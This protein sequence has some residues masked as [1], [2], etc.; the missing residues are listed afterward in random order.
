MSCDR[1]SLNG[2]SLGCV[3]ARGVLRHCMIA[4]FKIDFRD[5]FLFGHLRYSGQC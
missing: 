2:Q 4:R 3:G 5:V 1:P